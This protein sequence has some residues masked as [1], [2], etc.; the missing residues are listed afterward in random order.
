MYIFIPM[1]IKHAEEIAYNWKYEEPYSFYNMTED[2]EDLLE[3]LNQESWKDSS[4]AVINEQKEL[5]GFFQYNI[6]NSEL[7]IGLGLKPELTGTGLGEKFVKSGLTYG[8]S[9]FKDKAKSIKLSVASSNARAIKIYQKLGFEI[10]KQELVHTNKKDYEFFVMK[11]SMPID[12]SSINDDKFIKEWEKKRTKGKL[13]YFIIEI[14]NFI[15][16][17]II[18]FV[19][20]ILLLAIYQILFKDME[21]AVLLEIFKEVFNRLN[22]LSFSPFFAVLTGTIIGTFLNW[23]ENEKRYKQLLNEKGRNQ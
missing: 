17:S 5:V 1:N 10:D 6:D 18:L 14:I 11:K 22:I 8:I 21:I 7:V 16:G 19:I 9:K 23:R 3:F 4:Y 12:E 15:M 20:M 13:N 2:E